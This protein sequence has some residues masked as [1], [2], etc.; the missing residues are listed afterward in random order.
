MLCKAHNS[1]VD[2][3]QKIV[4]ACLV[5]VGSGQLTFEI[6]TPLL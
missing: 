2:A 3:H 1:V 6:V 4:I 5:F